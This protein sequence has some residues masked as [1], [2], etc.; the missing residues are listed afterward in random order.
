[1]KIITIVFLSIIFSLNVYSDDS[2]NLNNKCKDEIRKSCSGIKNVFGCLA[3]NK[4]KLS[5][6]CKSTLSEVESKFKMIHKGCADDYINKCDNYDVLNS[7]DIIRC[8][9]T[10]LEK[11]SSQCQ[12]QADRCKEDVQ[13]FCNNVEKKDLNLIGRCIY[14]NL[15]KL[16]S[17]CRDSLK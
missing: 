4:E 6:A 8:G 15:D 12:Y 13:K 17:K 10:N 3:K 7:R 2:R 5:S 11:F 1:M 16:S 9:A 14:S